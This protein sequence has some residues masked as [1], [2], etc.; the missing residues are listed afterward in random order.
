MIGSLML[1]NA[2]ALGLEPET[3]ETKPASAITAT[4]A[5][6]NGVLNPGMAGEPGTYEFLY[7]ASTT[8][9]VG[10][11]VA[12]EPAGIALGA[13]QE[14][15]SVEVASLQ[16]GTHYTFC[17]LARNLAEEVTIGPP[18]TFVTAAEAPA[19]M[20]EFVTDV[21]SDSTTLNARV[22][23]KGSETIFRF[24]YGPTVSYGSE[25]LEGSTGAA[26][27]PSMVEFNLQSLTPNTTYHY[28]LVAH[29]SAG[30]GS[31]ST[32]DGPDRTFTTQSAGL[33]GFVL[34]DGRA[35]EM[36][37]PLAKRGAV[38]EPLGTRANGEGGIVQSSANGGAITYLSDQSPL[39]APDGEANLS[40]LLSVRGGEGWASQDITTPNLAP[41]D[42]S[43]GR[44][45]EYRFFSL[46]LSL[47]LVEP[48][49]R[50]ST[51][52]SSEATE[53][54]PYL[55][56]QVASSY[57]PL[58][59]PAN[60]PPG[61]KFGGNPEALNPE[62]PVQLAGAT[63]DLS[64]IVL[65]SSGGVALTSAPIEGLYEWTASELRRVSVLPESEGGAPVRGALG[66]NGEDVRH[67]ISEDGARVF[68]SQEEGGVPHLYVRDMGKEESLKLDTIQP[69]A[70]GNEEAGPKF[71]VASA[72]GSLAFFTD[73]QQLTED[74]QAEMRSP[75][76]YECEV[77]EE[78]GKLACNLKDLTAGAGV[79][80]VV[81]GVSDD[82][83]Y[84]YFVANGVLAPGATAGNCSNEAPERVCNLYVL[85]NNGA[86]WTTTFIASLS[87]EDLNDW[88]GANSGS[89]RKV[90]SRVSPNGRYLAFMSARSLTGYDNTDVNSGQ[91]DEE[92]FLYDA[93][94]N[95]LVCAS[96]NP[97][98]A[99]PAGVLDGES[100]LVDPAGGDE[101]AWSSRWLAGLIPEW[102]A[103]RIGHAMYQSRYLSNSGRLFFDS[104]D[105][106]VPQDVNGMMDVYE[107]EP[108]G[109]PSGARSCSSSAEAFAES[110]GGCIGLISS[111]ESDE[112][113][114]FLDA[115]ESGGDV[116]FLTAAQ[117]SSQDRDDQFDV[118]D[119]HECTGE[120][121]CITA[122]VI[123]P[124]QCSTGESCKPAA[125][126]QPAIFGA[127][128]SA[129]FSGL[130]NVNQQPSKSAGLTRAQKLAK[131]LKVC[132]KRSRNK[133]L[134]CERR[135]RRA[136]GSTRKAKRSHNGGKS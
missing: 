48:R 90:T 101:H 72:D 134:V 85:H 82:D 29:N 5:T 116:F 131:A 83:S 55:R 20:E 30:G 19:I 3:P 73:T 133:R 44:G 17:L 56:N 128:S 87:S 63:S 67:A 98:G 53:R 113:S 96:C 119:A 97:S 39:A 94:A 60:V 38:M 40:Q 132:R 22:D 106:L 13:A 10:G 136:Y 51:P 50:K 25:S 27:G 69:G 80:G 11:S 66:Y 100:L 114:A 118:Y 109:V 23:P 75:D 92:V 77:I 21:S 79:Q 2:S 43:V 76:L 45:Q 105:A 31:G 52:L 12:P 8:E 16:P 99:R 41:T 104:P 86:A 74:S 18:A 32:V 71:Q 65:I 4:T 59:T 78:A 9:C 123:P 58:L 107:Y 108:E 54:T 129:T 36:V 35:W 84:V 26:S 70:S 24:E 112:E 121:P 68:W 64:H 103:I 37:S 61:T 14:P 47:A 28:R 91:A 115:S 93:S 130:G 81:L 57:L 34:P 111:G 7:K 95:R 120:S 42:V 110:S 102:T 122:P 1:C 126:P 124:E 125:S 46:D 62:G 135:A 49:G 127:P 89:V 15:E 33:G 88:G 6:L 117:L